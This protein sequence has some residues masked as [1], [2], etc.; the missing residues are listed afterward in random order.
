MEKNVWSAEAKKN[1]KGKR[2]KHLGKKRIWPVDEKMS[3]EGKGRK[4][5]EGKLMVTLTTKTNNRQTG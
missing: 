2:A 5:G 3:R 1:R 4:F